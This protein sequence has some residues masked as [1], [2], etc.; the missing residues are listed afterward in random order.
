MLQ[1]LILTRPLAA[2]QGKIEA[3]RCRSRGGKQYIPLKSSIST[4]VAPR[5]A[6]SFCLMASGVTPEF[7]ALRAAS[8]S[9]RALMIVGF[10]ESTNSWSSDFV[11]L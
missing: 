10:E 11:S 2:D 7:A 3:L 8:S 9:V 4:C 1:K 5:F 6:S